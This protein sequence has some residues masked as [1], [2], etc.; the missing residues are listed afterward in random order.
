MAREIMKHFSNLQ[1]L[2]DASEEQLVLLPD[3]GAVTAQCIVSYFADEENRRLLSEAAALGLPMEAET[4]QTGVALEGLTIVITGTLP[5]LGRSQAKELIE[6]NGGKCTGSVSKKTNYL[7]AGE[8]AGSKL[9]KA[10]A[11]GVPVITEQELLAMIES[12]AQ[13]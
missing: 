11:L 1:Q 7:L 3:V 10:K 13:G 5:T 6:Q 8:A 12:P 9:E 2:A 4:S